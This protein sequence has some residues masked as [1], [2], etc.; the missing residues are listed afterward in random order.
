MI[1]DYQAIG[2]TWFPKGQQKIIPTFGRHYGAKLIGALDYATGEVTCIQ[3]DR[4]TAIEFLQF[5]KM[6]VKKYR[7]KRIIMILDNASIHHASL[8][9][10]FLND[11]KDVLTLKFLPP[12]SPNL[13]MIEEFWGWLKATVIHNVFFS[14]LKEIK[15]AVKGFINHVNLT[16]EKTL[17][18]ICLQF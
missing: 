8:L 3:R 15:R 12:Y 1:R 5:L 17:E 2:A 9:E 7:G 18:R 10:D 11:H 4:Y 13:N 16:P 6:I 14:N